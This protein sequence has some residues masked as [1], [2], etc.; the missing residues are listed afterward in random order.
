M[1]GSWVLIVIIL[2]SSLPVIAVYV[3]FRAAKYKISTVQFMFALLAGA[4]AFVPALILQDVLNFPAFSQNRAA[5][6][7]EFFVR[8]A[9]SEELS[10]LLLLFIFFWISSLVKPNEDLSQP[11]S[12]NI[13][14]KGTAIGL[15]AGLGFAVL[16]SARIAVSNMDTGLLLLR[17]FSAVP[18]HAACG[19]R[20]GAAA[21]MFRS[22]PVQALLRI[23]TA[24]AIHGVYNLMVIIP[25]LPSIIA[26]VI[27][28]SAFITAILTIRDR[29]ET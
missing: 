26:I 9:L 13:V 23:L 22:T 10:R 3:W 25:G 19:S 27:A 1:L 18:L 12:L 7:Y 4:A 28:I 11:L 17:I 6:F 24:V 5:L 16:E 2:I 8:I 29:K 21:L 15:V 20:V 14:Q